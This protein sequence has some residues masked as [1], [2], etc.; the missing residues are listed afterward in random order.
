MNSN[1]QNG[2]GRRRP[3]S[4]PPSSAGDSPRF[5]NLFFGHLRGFLL[6]FGIICFLGA[7]YFVAM[8]GFGRALDQ[9]WRENVGYPGI[10]DTYA[11]SGRADATLEAV[12]N[13]CKSRSDFVRLDR[14]QRLALEGFDGLYSGETALAKAADYI[15]CLTTRQRERFCNAAHRAHLVTALNDYYKLM[16][17]VREER[18][19]VTSNPFWTEKA[20]LLG[21]PGGTLR[22]MDRPPSAQSDQRV[23]DGLKALIVDGYLSRRSLGGFFGGLPGDLDTAMHGVEPKHRACG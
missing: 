3:A 23:V 2:F 9:H 14:N 17:K 5:E 6:G 18:L 7:V 8:K 15:S 12:H 10:E 4:K 22:N 20:A 21:I 16:F 19:F 13:D 1:D 11:R